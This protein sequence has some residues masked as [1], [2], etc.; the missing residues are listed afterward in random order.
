MKNRGFIFFI[1]TL[2]IGLLIIYLFRDK[3][4][5]NKKQNTSVPGGIDNTDKF[6]DVMPIGKNDIVKNDVVPEIPSLDKNKLL[7][8]GVKGVEVKQLQEMINKALTGLNKNKLV[9]DGA[10]GQKT[11]EALYY[12]LTIRTT[13]L[14]QFATKAIEKI[15]KK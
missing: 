6:P 8:R 12:L 9:V 10:F 3:I 13:T 1:L 5:P 15:K 4:F 14:A 2:A 7:K 11:E